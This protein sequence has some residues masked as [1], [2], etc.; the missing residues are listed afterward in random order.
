M[1]ITK[2][3]VTVQTSTSC[4]G[5]TPGTKAA[6]SVTGG[7][8]DCRA[9]YGGDLTYIITNGASAPGVAPTLVFQS[10]PD[11]TNW[12]DYYQ[13]GGDTTASSVNSNTILLDQG[14]MY[15]R[16]IA[17]GN[18]TNA[19]TIAASLQAITAI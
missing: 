3:A 9:Y 17:Y 2:S 12:F 8:I 7:A 5:A 4:G 11:G 13:V 19:V 6:P 15:M 16:L 1:A 14:I 10:S 18:T